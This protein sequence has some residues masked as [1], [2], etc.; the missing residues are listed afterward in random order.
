M[1]THC[2]RRQRPLAGP[3]AGGEGDRPGGALGWGWGLGPG[4]LGVGALGWGLG[5]GDLDM[6]ELA[7]K[8]ETAGLNLGRSLALR[9][10]LPWRGLGTGG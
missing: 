3:P 4:D 5:P 7:L 10:S 6:K 9:G 2:R 8:D 1:V